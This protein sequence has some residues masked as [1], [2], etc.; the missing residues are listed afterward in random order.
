MKITIIGVGKIKEK[1]FSQAIDEYSKRLGRYCRLEI[2]QLQDEKT[3]ERAGIKEQAIILDK[4]GERILSAIDDNSYIIALDI[5][6]MQI[7]SPGLARKIEKL[8]GSGE[9]HFTFIIGG[10]LG[11]SEKVLK[12]A[13][14]RLSF[15]MLTFPHQLMRVM[16]L[17]QIY[18]SFR[19]INHEPYHK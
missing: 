4:E 12:R 1:F 8:M 13:D 3:P 9:S 10:S 5:A 19:I 7:D 11:L 16:L 6:G 17:E 15:G 18:K 14:E 2:I